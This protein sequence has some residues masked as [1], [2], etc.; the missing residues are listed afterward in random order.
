MIEKIAPREYSSRV[1]WHRLHYNHGSPALGSFFI[2]GAVLCTGQAELAHVG[3]V[4]TKYTSIFKL[5]M[6]QLDGL[7]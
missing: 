5:G 2:V 4:G 6:P 7:Q 1:Y 3:G